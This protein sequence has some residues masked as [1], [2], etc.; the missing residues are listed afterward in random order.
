[1]NRLAAR[2]DPLISSGEAQI[3]VIG[4]GYVGLPVACVL[5]S[6]GYR[7]VGVELR[8]DRVDTINSGASP[9]EGDEPGLAELLADVV[10]A[11]RLRATCSAGELSGADIVLINV[12]TPVDD[13]DHRPHYEALQQACRSLGAVLRRGA[14]VIVESTIA[15]GTMDNVVRPILEEVSGFRA[16]E[17]FLL[18]HCPE[19]V[20]PG[21]L[22]ANLRQ[23]SRICGGGTAEAAQVMLALYRHWVEADLD[24]ADCVSAEIVKTAENAYRDVNIAFANELA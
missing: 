7:V 17:D 23:M 5:A 20:M 8:A 12:E 19:R 10:H 4:L 9:I 11:G 16:G 22:L 3:G 1:M 14:L 2:L 18:G 6:K 21:K 24:A 15:P 13:Q